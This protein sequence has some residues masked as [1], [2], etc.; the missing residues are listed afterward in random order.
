MPKPLTKP[1]LYRL[2]LTMDA[3]KAAVCGPNK[4]LFKP[5]RS[6]LRLDGRIDVGISFGLLDQLQTAA[7]PK[8]NLSD[9]VLRIMA[10][11]S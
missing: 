1:P 10:P 5:S 3:V 8:E 2:T 11:K 7:L 4:K 9:T 6:A